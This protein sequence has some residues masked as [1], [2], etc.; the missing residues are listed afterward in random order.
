MDKAKRD[1]QMEFLDKQDT[2]EHF[3]KSMPTY[4]VKGPNG[5]TRTCRCAGTMAMILTS[6]FSNVDVWLTIRR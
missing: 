6:E 2:R 3:S 1:K 5:E 4:V